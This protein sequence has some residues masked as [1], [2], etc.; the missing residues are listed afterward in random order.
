MMKLLQSRMKMHSQRVEALQRARVY[1][2]VSL[3]VQ[4]LRQHRYLQPA[5]RMQERQLLHFFQIQETDI[6]QQHFLMNS[7]IYQKK[8]RDLKFKS[9]LFL[10]PLGCI[11]LK[12]DCH[13]TRKGVTKCVCR[14][15]SVKWHMKSE[16]KFGRSLLILQNVMKQ[17]VY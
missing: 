3:Q 8:G 7:N 9:L 14:Q 5:Q 15:V 6:F 12:K 17:Q 4:H 13:Y 1:L 10:Y 2:L 11:L 16:Y